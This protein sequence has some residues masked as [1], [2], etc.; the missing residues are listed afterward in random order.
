MEKETKLRTNKQSRSIHKMFSEL[1]REAL[2][3]GI[4]RKTVINSL[5]G[6]SCPLDEAFIKEV[7]RA[8]MFT[9]TGK[10]ST[11]EITTS[12][13]DKVYETFNRFWGENFGIS[14]PFPSIEALYQAEWYDNQK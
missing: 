1:A 11:T 9:Q 12:E 14:C 3:R 10:K 5:E 13:I 8:I 2:E 7:W 6:Y 4:E